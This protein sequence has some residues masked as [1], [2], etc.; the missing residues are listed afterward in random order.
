[1]ETRDSI[2]DVWGPRTPNLRAQ[3]PPPPDVRL[4]EEPETWVQSWCVLCSTGCGLDIGVRDGRMVGVRGRTKDRVNKG[5]LGPK[6]LHGWEANQAADRLTTP[7]IRKD[8]E[9]VE[10]SW[11]EAMA[12]IVVKSLACKS[13]HGP[14][15]I[16]FYNSGQLFLEEYYTLSTIADAGIG[17]TNIDGNTRLCTATAAS[18]LIESFGTD[19]A[20]GS[21][22]DFDLTDAIFMVGHNMP[23]TQTVL[24]ARVLDRLDGPNPPK[25]IVV[26]PR[27]TV[28]ARRADVHLAPRPGTNLALMNGL[29]HAIIERG[30]ID[31]A[32]IEAHTTGIGD[33][34]R[35]TD[36]WTLERTA[37]VT[38]IPLEQLQAAVEILA[39]TPTLVSTC[40]Q[41]V[42]QSLQATATAVQVNNLHLIRGLIGKPGS[43]VFQMNGQPTAQN[44]RECGANGEFIAFR[45]WNNADHI[46]ET[47]KVWNVEPSTLPTWT[48]PTDAMTMWRYCE[49]GAIRMLWILGTN[50]AVSL[51]ETTRIHK[52]LA[53][54]D[55]FVVVSDAFLTETA[56]RADVVLPAAIWGEKTGC[57]TNP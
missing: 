55:L 23:S 30:A 48:P 53:S 3:W 35:T 37:G 13:E 43:T 10:A 39:T 11:D 20:P 16:G 5:R 12:L 40:L 29:L 56:R 50:P 19:G 31:S 27:P 36:P 6:G 22:T 9:L 42:Y 46:A 57:G 24:W 21:F 2:R 47:A 18:A 32:W 26:D 51:P 33:L 41:G 15:S 49:N 44:T 4:L 1:M 7:L 17:T 14:G 52:I 8:G 45:N 28:A 25:L 38:G 54:R 34:V